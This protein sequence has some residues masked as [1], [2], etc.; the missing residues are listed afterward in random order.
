MEGAQ[1]AG[2]PARGRWSSPQG[3]LSKTRAH[4]TRHRAPPPPCCDLQLE[5]R[6]AR[7]AGASIIIGN[8]RCG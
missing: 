4:G 3:P 7:G 1:P 5:S 8:G 6:V 2:L